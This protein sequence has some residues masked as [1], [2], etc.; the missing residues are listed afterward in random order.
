MR[1]RLPV[2]VT[3]TEIYF[4]IIQRKVLTPNDFTSTDQ[5]ESSILAFQERYSSLATPFAW[6]F[7]RDDLHR[8]LTKVETARLAA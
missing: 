6:R 7:T 8:L 2:V 4:S 3:T 5:V 1:D